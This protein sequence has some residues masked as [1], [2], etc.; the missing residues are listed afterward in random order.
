MSS[1]FYSHAYVVQRK[2]AWI[3]FICILIFGGLYGWHTVQVEWLH[4]RDGN[5]VAYV[6]GT[7]AALVALEIAL[8]VAIAIQSPRE[9]RTPKDER[10][11]LIDLRASRVA[12]YVLFVGT[13]LS[14]GLGM[15][16]PG[17]NRFL[18]AQ[19]LMSAIITTL[20][21]RFGIQIVLYRRD[22]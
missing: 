17:S 8:H 10:E 9:A 2:S 12:F 22:A 11:Q 4:A 21:V 20:L 19:L 5:S 15:H 7:I 1:I 6:F 16:L 14:L 18:M 13:L 3:S